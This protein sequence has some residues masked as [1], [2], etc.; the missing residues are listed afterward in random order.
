MWT[1]IPN[2]LYSEKVIST[3]GGFGDSFASLAARSGISAGD[4]WGAGICGRG[5]EC[6]IKNSR[7]GKQKDSCMGVVVKVGGGVYMRETSLV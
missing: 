1:T 6:G 5:G 2:R 4:N 3:T 7:C